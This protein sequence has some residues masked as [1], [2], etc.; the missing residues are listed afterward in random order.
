MER[1]ENHSKKP[2]TEK[3]VTKNVNKGSTSSTCQ[4]SIKISKD[5]VKED[6]HNFKALEDF[7]RLALAAIA[8]KKFGEDRAAKSANGK[9]EMKGRLILGRKLSQT[10]RL[11]SSQKPTESYLRQITCKENPPSISRIE[12]GSSKVSISGVGSRRVSQAAVET[13][14]LIARHQKKAAGN[15][16]E[17][18]MDLKHERPNKNTLPEMMNALKD[19][20]YLRSPNVDE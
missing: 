15:G 7:R 18:S 9:A 12:T 19:C 6:E 13:R 5:F 4:K 8:A 16:C 11:E 17:H 2:I 14:M 20:R 3:S 1:R 10:S